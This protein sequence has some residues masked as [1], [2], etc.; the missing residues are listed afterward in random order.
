MLYNGGKKLNNPINDNVESRKYTTYFS[1][2]FIIFR[3]RFIEIN[4]IITSIELVMSKNTGSCIATKN[5]EVG[6][7]N[8]TATTKP[9]NVNNKYVT[10]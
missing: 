4:K 6:C 5:I 1:I 7:I 10:H 9:V 3:F 2:L 8:D